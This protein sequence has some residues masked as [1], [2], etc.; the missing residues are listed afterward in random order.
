MTKVMRSQNSE[1]SKV[2]I[3]TG[4]IAAVEDYDLAA[5]R[6]EWC[7]ACHPDPVHTQT[8]ALHWHE[9]EQDR[10]YVEMLATL[11]QATDAVRAS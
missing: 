6:L 4:L 10:A 3:V 2:D 5:A 11:R 8:E 1:Q 9:Q 7:R